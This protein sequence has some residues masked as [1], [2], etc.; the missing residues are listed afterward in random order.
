MSSVGVGVPSRRWK[1]A[2]I[3]L[4]VLVALL[5][6][7]VAVATVIAVQ[8]MHRSQRAESSLSAARRQITSLNDQ[9]AQVQAVS[10]RQQA[11][12]LQT[13]VVLKAVDPLLSDADQLQQLTG[14]IQGQR[15][16]F[17]S[18]TDRLVTDLLDLYNALVDA[19]NYEGVDF[20]YLNPSVDNVNAELGVVR[21]DEYTLGTADDAYGKASTKFGNHA[22]AFTMSVRNLQTKLQ[23]LTKP[24]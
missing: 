16:T 11:I 2:T 20:S 12:L 3:V 14:T 23:S 21:A 7:G 8:Q 9:L 24:K 19:A 18:D 4:S 1:R 22:D 17:S 6:A 15:D 13:Q 5:V 10:E